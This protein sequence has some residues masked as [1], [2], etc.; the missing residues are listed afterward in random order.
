MGQ[1]RNRLTMFLIAL[2]IAVAAAQNNYTIITLYSDTTC[3]A[4]AR[5][6]VYS[7][8]TTAACTAKGCTN[9]YSISCSTTNATF[10][11]AGNDVCGYNAYTQ[12]TSC[13]DGP[14]STALRFTTS[15][16]HNIDLDDADLEATFRGGIQAAC[17]QAGNSPLSGT[18][19]IKSIRT[20]GCVGA[21]P[22]PGT[23]SPANLICY[24]STNCANP[25]TTTTGTTGTTSNVTT[26]ATTTPSPFLC[27]TCYQSGGVAYAPTNPFFAFCGAS[28]LQVSVAVIG[29]VVAFVAA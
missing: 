26:V 9:G 23:I 13:P 16:C 1:P 7:F 28:F 3:T 14:I 10:A 15:A 18:S 5:T 22:N 8:N 6:A 21:G 12:G 27:R 4:T 20:S 17:W 24:T 25:G 11:D 19:N 29:L 2:L